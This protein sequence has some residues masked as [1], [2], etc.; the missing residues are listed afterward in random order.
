[1]GATLARQQK[2]SRATFINPGAPVN[3]GSNPL[4]RLSTANAVV[5]GRLESLTGGKHFEGDFFESDNDPAA[6]YDH[7]WHHRCHILLCNLT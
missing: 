5:D 7:A 1:M 2:G 6:W 4:I 3:S